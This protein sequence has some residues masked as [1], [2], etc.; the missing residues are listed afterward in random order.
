MRI[1][2]TGG[3][4]G[5]HFFPLL[6]VVR[7]VKRSAEE[8]QIIDLDLFYM[9]PQM[10]YEALMVDEDVAI[11]Y[12]SC[13]KM[14]RY[15]SLLNIVDI[16]RLLIG[17]VQALWKMF[18]LVPDV[19]FSKGGY[20]AFPVTIAAAIFRIPMIIHDSDA[21]PGAVTKFS[22][23]FARR[24]G[25]AFPSAYSY[26][27]KEKTALVGVP[28][29]KRILGGLKEEARDALNVFSALPVLGIIGASQGAQ[30]INDAVL[31]ILKELSAKYEILHQTG[32]KNIANVM[33]EAKIILEFNHNEHYH[34]VAFLKEAEMRDFY[35]VSDLIISRAGATS[36]F[37]IAAWGKP[38]IVIPLRNSAQDHQEK[39]A[40]A[41][42]AEG[43][44]VVIQEENLTPH[45][46]MAEIDKLIADPERMKKMGEAAQRFARVDAAEALAKEILKL[47]VHAK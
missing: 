41:Y 21:V 23:R 4:T 15:F 5:G 36:I 13:G 9:G 29:R 42:A 7:E 26:F 37:E 34:P 35:L 39:N 20:A 6:A 43:A 44:C 27:P 11:F 22:A 10:P 33:G 18:F 1:L 24:I 17:T 19:I 38:S 25:I 12:I 32:E 46:L 8:N 14:R 40:Y 47:G 16:F 28:I 30:K 31:G 2:F 3:G 45:L